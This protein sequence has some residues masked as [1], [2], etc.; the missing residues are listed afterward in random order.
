[1]AKLN[2]IICDLCNGLNKCKIPYVLSLAAG[3]GQDR[4][5]KK[6]EIC[7]NC[8][9]QLSDDID[10]E[11]DLTNFSPNPK[12]QAVDLGAGQ[13]II[14]SQVNN[15]APPPGRQAESKCAHDR[16]SMELDEK[17]ISW[18]TCRDCDHKWKEE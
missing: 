10:S 11:F 2:L 14:P 1:M 9:D 6:A 18:F 12:S 15:I 5:V 17:D 3:K 13:T 7:K 4:E 8:Y 16:K